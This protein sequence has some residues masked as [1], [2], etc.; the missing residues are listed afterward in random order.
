MNRVVVG[1]DDLDPLADFLP[2]AL[3]AALAFGDLDAGGTTVDDVVDGVELGG[4]LLG[5]GRGLS[6]GQELGQGQNRRVDGEDATEAAWGLALQR[7]WDVGGLIKQ[8]SE[9]ILE[10]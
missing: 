4:G 8:V 5:F 3:I 1:L 10:N 6:G 7:R 2:G 9:G